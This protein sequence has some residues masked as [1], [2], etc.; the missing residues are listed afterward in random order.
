MDKVNLKREPRVD[1]STREKASS[2]TLQRY[3]L[4]GVF[5]LFLLSFLL[6]GCYHKK[7]P[8]SFRLPGLTLL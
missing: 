3:G 8:S 6:T 4:M 5:L 7:T 1:F 2:C